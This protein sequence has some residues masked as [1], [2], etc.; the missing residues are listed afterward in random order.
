MPAIPW[1][2]FREAQEGKEY[3]AL[4]SMLPLKSYWM[5]PRLTRF[6]FATQQQ[7]K[8]AHG[9]IGYSLYAELRRKRFYTLSVWEDRQA[10]MDFVEEIPHGEIMQ[11]LKPH[12]GES[13]FVEWKA[14]AAEIPIQWKGALKRAA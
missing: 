11:K 10:L 14:R 8:G 12:M 4:L 3:V 13:R 6:M 9:L 2:S 5:V 7:L 1:K